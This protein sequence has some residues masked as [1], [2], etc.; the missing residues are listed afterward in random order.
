LGWSSQAGLPSD[1]VL[2]RKNGCPH[3]KRQLGVD[4]VDAAGTIGK[5][6]ETRS[7]GHKELARVR[8]ADLLLKH[9]RL[10]IL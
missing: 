3:R 5:M 2:L 8:E 10:R 1:N 7:D 4:D 6:L 9:K